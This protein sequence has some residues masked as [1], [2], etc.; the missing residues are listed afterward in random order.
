MA[1]RF[2]YPKV[3]G[4]ARKLIDKFGQTG[5]LLRYVD[6]TGQ[7]GAKTKPSFVPE[8]AIF[9]VLNYED[10]KVDGTRITERDRWIF[11]STEGLT[12]PPTLQD[13]LRDVSGQEY[14]IVPPLKPLNPAGHVV[15][16][17]IQGR[18]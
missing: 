5:E 7:P 1:K 18:L 14:N 2:N 13:K 12:A 17:E 8:P 10:R 15:F 9:V 4:T 6:G 11:L 16:Y 3:E